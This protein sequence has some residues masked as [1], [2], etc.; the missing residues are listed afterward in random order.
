MVMEVFRLPLK[1]EASDG[2]RLTADREVTVAS[3]SS[4]AA[5]EDSSWE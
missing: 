5:V 1:A 4:P 2:V 3:S